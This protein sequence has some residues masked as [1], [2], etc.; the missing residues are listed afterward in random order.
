MGGRAGEEG[1]GAGT[2]SGMRGMRLTMA[3]QTA[4]KDRIDRSRDMGYTGIEGRIDGELM[5]HG[6]VR[7]VVRAR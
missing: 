3:M 6:R 4:R 7:V 5:L 1:K 2:S